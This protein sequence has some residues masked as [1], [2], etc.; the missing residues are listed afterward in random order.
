[1]LTMPKF[2]LSWLLILASIALGAQNAPKRPLEHADIAAWKNLEQS[3]ISADGRWVAYVVKPNEGDSELRIYDAQTDRTYP[4][5]RGENP[6]FSN[7][8]RYV[9][10]MIKPQRDSTMAM[11]RR[12]VKKDDLP[13]DTLGIYDLRSM[14][15]TKI[16]RVKNF[17]LP[18]KWGGWLVYHREALKVEPRAPKDSLILTR[19]KESE[20]NGTG[21]VIINLTDNTEQVIGYVKTYA[22]APEKARLAWYST[23]DNKDQK[24]GVYVFDGE[25]KR[26]L[27]A[28]LGKGN[29]KTLQFNRPG[30]QLAMLCDLDSTKVRIRPWQLQVW[31]LAN[32][33]TQTVL[34]PGNAFLPKDWGLS[35]NATLSFAKDGSKLFFGIAPA[36]TLADTSVLEEEIVNMEVWHYQDPLIYPQQKVQLENERK[37]AYTCVW[38]T[39]ENKLVQL[40]NLN[41]RDIRLGNEG[42]ASHVIGL[43]NQAYQVETTW[44]LE[45]VTDAYLIDLQTGKAELLSKGIHGNPTFSPLA[46]YV[47]WFSSK[48]TAWVA[49]NL[50][51]KASMRLTRN[52]RVAFYDELHDSPSRPSM[53]GYAGW[54]T[55]DDYLLVYDRY[56][57]WKLDPT[58]QLKATNLT[59]GRAEQIT[60]R[61]IRVDP[62]ER[63][64]EEVKPMLLH[65]VN[66]KTKDES[67]LYYDIHSG[68][69]KTLQQGP[70]DYSTQVLK[71]KNAERWVFRKGNFQTY[72]DL[73]YSTDL[74]KSKVISQAN[75][76]Q[77]QYLWGSNELVEWTSA[78]GERLSGMLIKPEGFDPKKKYPMI[79]YF[80][81]RMSDDLH[82]HWTP[83]WSRSM[84]NFSQLASR[85]FLV[86]I[87]DIP[88]RIGYPGESCEDAVVSGV[89]ALVDKG[90]VD[91]ANLGLQG[92]S[93]GG[94]Q[95]AYLVTQT[96]LF[97]CA[98][99]GAPVVN[100][101]SAYG[102]IRWESGLSRMFQYEQS[103][104]RIGA[105]LWEK[106]LRYLENSP[107]FFADK[108]ETPLLIMHNDKDG[109]VPW[110]QGIEFYMAM[111]RLNKP[112]WLLN[113]NEEGH[114]LVKMQNRKDFQLRMLQFFEHYLKGAV[115]PDWMLKGVPAASKPR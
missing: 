23:G 3:K 114:G 88:Y 30:T 105:T 91:K 1:M 33:Q 72:P 45:N 99:S 103:Q 61:Y 37:R 71:A 17:S 5:P 26:I 54:T 92:H 101:V 113:Y 2:Y 14:S 34:S 115:M 51:K 8:S 7:D 75:P 44:S 90:F 41:I 104:S 43:N 19:K 48:D 25:N 9:A 12:K 81:E 100:M 69:K 35:E 16:G 20:E 60:S 84:L 76:Q 67:Y 36:P 4:V 93:W 87:P 24:P 66:E 109:A 80:Y 64:I 42:N 108:I 65:T 59:N 110:Y 13:K 18:E 82:T 79:T 70:F 38:H 107:I 63:S 56:D 40:G 52:D 11:R 83:S 73:S 112:A 10:F 22:A 62:E 6:A 50:A 68:K 47:F 55:D 27:P 106:P 39:A 49:Y 31:S 85:G 53:Y 89:T 58:G 98:E 15:L 86:F 28:K 97:K 102:G 96:N 78:T 111:R 74:V 77:A 21:L 32:N 46:K 29:F 57:I 95:I 94:Y